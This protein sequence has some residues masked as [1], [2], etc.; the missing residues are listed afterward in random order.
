MRFTN[1]LHN[2]Q[3]SGGTETGAYTIGNGV[4]EVRSASAK[5]WL[6]SENEW[7]K[8]AYHDASAGTAGVYF[9]YATGSDSVPTVAT[10]N[11]VGDISNPG[12]GVVNYLSGADWNGQNG[13]V[14]TVGSAGIASA[15]PYGTFDQNGNVDEWNEAVISSSFRGLRGGSWFFNS[16]DL[17]AVYRGG[18]NPT[19]EDF[20]V[21]F[22]VATVP[23][24]S[25]LLMGALA[26][27][28]LLVRRKR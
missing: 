13:N 28:G 2:G 18:F 27:A 7:Y 9:D 4:N 14:T 15:S 3:G 20:G 11:S 8:A 16:G 19:L 22:R 1:W 26:A 25:S 12:A 5:F 10:A 23:E 24:P 17:R 6:P 21:G